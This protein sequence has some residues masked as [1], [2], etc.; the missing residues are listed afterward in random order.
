MHCKNTINLDNLFR[1]LKTKSC[2]YVK[3]G[4]LNSF[5]SSCSSRPSKISTMS[6][7]KHSAKNRRKKKLL[8]AKY[9][10]LAC[11]FCFP[12]KG[13]VIILYRTVSFKFCPVHVNM[14][15]LLKRQRVNFPWDLYWKKKN[16]TY[17]LKKSIAHVN[18]SLLFLSVNCL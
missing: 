13:H 14:Y 18:M 10:S 17:K 1:S 11:M 4:M 3:I 6:R 12:N 7:T 5:S 9:T 16:K 8:T 15:A 2:T